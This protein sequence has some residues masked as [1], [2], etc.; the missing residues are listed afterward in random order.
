MDQ[1]LGRELKPFE[2]VH[3]KNGIRTDNRIENLELWTKPQT[4]GQRVIDLVSWVIENYKAEVKTFFECDE[5]A[6]RVLN[7]GK[8]GV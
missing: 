1:H 5:A 4:S 2:N 8:C 7:G 6:N 3:H